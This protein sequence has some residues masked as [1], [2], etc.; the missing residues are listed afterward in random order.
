MSRNI[1][2]G[3]YFKFIVYVVIVIL[4]NLAGITLFFRVDL[5]SGN[6]YSLSEASKEAVETLS[7]PLTINVFFTRDLPAPHNN[8]RRYLHDMLEEYSVNSNEYFNYRFYDVSVKEGDLKEESRKN[9]QLAHSYGI[10]PVQIKNIEQDEVQFKKAYMGMAMVH[11][12]IIDK[13]PSITST[14]GLEY[15][16]TSKIEKMND[17]ISALLNLEEQIKVRLYYSSSLAKIAP[18]INM[19]E[20]PQLPE[21]IES[22][23]ASLNDKYYSRLDFE[24]RNP[25]EDSSLEEEVSKYNVMTLRW[26][27]MKDESG[28]TTIE[29]GHGSI[30]IVV[31][32]KEKY[33]TIELINV[34]NMPIFGTQYQLVDLSNIEETISEAID[35]VIDINKKI[36]YLTSHGSIPLKGNAT[37]STKSI[38]NFN[39]LLSES[40]SVS[41]VDLKENDIPEGIDCLIIAGPKE[42]FSEYEL[43]EIDQ[44]LMSGKSVAFFLDPFEQIEPS[45]NQMQRRYNNRPTYMPIKT[46]LEKLLSNYGAET[47]SS[48]VLDE[49]C[50]E[51]N[52]P[53]R[54]GGGK[55]KVYFAPLIK[56]KN[57]NNKM[58]F[59]RN[60][61]AL[62]TLKASPVKPLKE[63]IEEIGV[64]ENIL[65]S[66]SER[67]WEMSEQISLNPM[68]TR[69]PQDPSKFR[70]FSLSL[71]LEGEFPS[72]FKNREIPEKPA[73]ETEESE[74]ESGEEITGVKP[75]KL[76]NE[77]TF[78]TKGNPGKIFL[79]G[80]SEL[81]S[82]SIIDE[83]GKAPSSTFAMNLIDRLNDREAYAS[84]RSKQQRFNPLD[85]TSTGSR[86]FVKTFNIAGLPVLV[87]LFGIIIWMRRES[88]KRN[89]QRIFE[90]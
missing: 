45:G 43:F 1:Q 9:Q 26:P 62:V 76:S 54:Y 60:I 82:N 44:F 88:K 40:Y 52:M 3:K 89:I 15:K 6:I 51:Q 20:L 35:N 75:T 22:A 55:Q 16:I 64:T 73:E 81:L 10:Y 50:Y 63:R 79:T 23:L 77:K 11:G 87:I 48:Y 68:M 57:I 61:K 49:E 47:S 29:E 83:T 70:S 13:I 33:E 12:D 8:T 27:A 58:E 24:R 84:M 59:M 53:R 65:F 42:N 7:E 31:I 2:T 56:N 86:A 66:S 17:K 18:K 4:I 39:S 69:P 72:Y 30:G 36:G 74:E 28:N 34:I 85:E 5:T 19:E 41:E 90:K 21:K 67:S 25:T 78:I 38:D 80:S 14:D 46:G 37:N 32:N 71:L